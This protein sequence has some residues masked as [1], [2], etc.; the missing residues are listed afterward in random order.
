M[1]SIYIAQ[2]HTRI[3]Q[4]VKLWDSKEEFWGNVN[5]CYGKRAMQRDI[6]CQYRKKGKLLVAW[7]DE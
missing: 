4:I 6:Y 3:R 7:Y 1:D 5:I 2:E